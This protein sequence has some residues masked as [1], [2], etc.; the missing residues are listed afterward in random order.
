MEELKSWIYF[1]A[2]SF[3]FGEGK[4]MRLKTILSLGNVV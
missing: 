1:A 2:P 4:R 3:S